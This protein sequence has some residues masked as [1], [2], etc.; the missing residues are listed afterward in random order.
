MFNNDRW[1][2][3]LTIPTLL[4]ATAVLAVCPVLPLLPF[5]MRAA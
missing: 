5:Q 1:H 3:L 2:R 4:V